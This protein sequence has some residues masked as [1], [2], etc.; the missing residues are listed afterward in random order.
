MSFPAISL[1]NL[2][3]SYEQH[4]VLEHVSWEVPE[5]AFVGVVGPNG[6]GKS[7]LLKI[8]LGLL[9]APPEKVSVFGK[10][11]GRALKEIGYLP[12]FMTMRLDFPMNAREVV[13][14]GRM[15]N[16]HL[17][18][19]LR[20][21]DEE[22]VDWALTVVGALELA[23]RRFGDLSG[24]QRQKVLLARA[25]AKKPRLLLLD[26]PTANVDSPSEVGLF[27]LLKSL[28][29]KNE[30]PMTIVVVSHDVGFV[31]AFVSEVACVN[32]SLVR[33]PAEGLTEE[34]LAA[35]YGVPVSAVHHHHSMPGHSH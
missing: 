19:R 26:E 3:F 7:T 23:T 31:S 5:G 24:G 10:A 33:H 20:G 21:E 32:R 22:A 9:P 30:N 12:Q 8:L 18:G 6:G 4:P 35:I 11:P 2:D 17:F 34:K 14:T 28:N 25:L 27:D 16:G 15:A 13:E 1:K 29:S